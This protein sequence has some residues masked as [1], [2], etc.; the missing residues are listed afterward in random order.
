[1]QSSICAIS[2]LFVIHHIERNAIQTQAYR[3]L[4]CQTDWT[5]DPWLHQTPEVGNHVLCR[6]VHL[7]KELPSSSSKGLKYSIFNGDSR[8]RA[9]SDRIIFCC[10]SCRADPRHYFNRVSLH[11]M[12]G[13]SHIEV[14]SYPSQQEIRN[15]NGGRYTTNIIFKKGFAP[16]TGARAIPP[17]L[18]DT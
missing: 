7:Q 4:G 16:H 17:T 2:K 5:N 8:S 12:P 1:M 10:S 3:R 6:D 18:L 9:F 15:F 13:T 11:S 14:A